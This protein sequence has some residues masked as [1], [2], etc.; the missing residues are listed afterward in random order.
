MAKTK[1]ILDLNTL[2]ERPTIRIDGETY[3]LRSPDEL[4]VL[5]SHF[6]T[7]KGKE[8]E[9]LGEAEG[10][11]ADLAAVVD[12]VV[13][14]MVIDLPDDVYDRL[15]GAAK[16]AIVDV[17]TGLLLR[18]RVSLAGAIA[19]AVIAPAKPTRSTGAKNSPASSASSEAIRTGGSGAPR[20]A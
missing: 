8:I 13:P 18:R 5:D 19:Q 2:I 9:Q 10:S 6:F 20:P 4:S 12:Q 17:F 16:L 11:D 1:P 3:E 14:R 7:V 15:S